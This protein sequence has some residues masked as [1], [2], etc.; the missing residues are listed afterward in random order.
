MQVDSLPP[1]VVKRGI[2]EF[3]NIPPGIVRPPEERPLCFAA[4]LSVFRRHVIFKHAER[5]LPKVYTMSGPR[6]DL[7]NSLI[8]DRSLP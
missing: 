6:L 4:V 2:E 8:F 1:R 3:E 5:P 7:K